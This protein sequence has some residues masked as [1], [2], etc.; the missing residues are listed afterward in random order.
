[1][2][3]EIPWT[4][5]CL[6]QLRTLW[7]E[8][9]PVTEIGR[10]MNRSK[11]AIVGKAHRLNLPGRDSPIKRVSEGYVCQGRKKPLVRTA[12]IY[13]PRAVNTFK[14]APPPVWVPPAI[15]AP[16]SNTRRC[17]WPMWDD[18]EAGKAQGYPTCNRWAL[19]RHGCWVCEDH[20]ALGFVCLK[21][22]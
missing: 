1:M 15:P 21:A 16:V 2:N 7:D 6:A 4:K 9:L 8:G 20:Y 19:A 12:R 17:G 10:R 5:E 11:N 3:N 14:P 22:A 18:R 13:R